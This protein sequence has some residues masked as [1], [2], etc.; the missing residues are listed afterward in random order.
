MSFG[1]VIERVVNDLDDKQGN[2][3]LNLKISQL[4]SLPAAVWS[5]PDP[6]RQERLYPNALDRL[7]DFARE[8]CALIGRSLQFGDLA[9]EGWKPS[10]QP[11]GQ[12]VQAPL[13]DASDVDVRSRQLRGERIVEVVTPQI[14]LSPGANGRLGLASETFQ[15]AAAAAEGSPLLPLECGPGIT[16]KNVSF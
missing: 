16:F 11:D 9:D 14:S 2:E 8:R 15:S 6:A 10:W 1:P 4:L 7:A 3:A 12:P 5:W 13:F